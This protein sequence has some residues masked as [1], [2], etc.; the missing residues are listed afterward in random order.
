MTLFLF[1][2]ALL[3]TEEQPAP[4]KPTVQM[5]VTVEREA[6]PADEVPAAVTVLR[7]EEIE[8]LP[9]RS[10]SGA[11]AFAPGIS[12]LFDDGTSGTP[13]ITSR[14][15]FGGGEVEYVKLL[16]DGAPVGDAESGLAD[17]QRFGLGDIERIEIVHG[18][19]SAVH[20]D[21]ALGGVIQLFTRRDEAL[22]DVRLGAGS[23][24]E[25]SLEGGAGG[26][27]GPLHLRARGSWR[28][29]DGFRDHASRDDASG[30]L[31]LDRTLDRSRWHV[32]GSASRVTRQDPGPLTPE[33]L[34]VSRTQSNE[35]FR[36]DREHVNRQRLAFGYDAFGSQTLQANVFAARRAS[37]NLRTI[38]LAPGFG[39]TALRDLVTREAGLSLDVSRPLLGGNVHA[40]GDVTRAA[41]RMRYDDDVA[42]ED[43]SRL[44]AGLFLTGAWN[45]CARCRLVLG[46]RH[47]S[48][49]DDFSS[50]R[51]HSRT[52][53]RAGFTLRVTPAVSLFAQLSRAFKAP[54]IEQLFDPRPFP[55][56]DGGTFTISYSGLRP[57][58][59]RNAELGVSGD[60]RA[61]RWSVAGYRMNVTD[62][63]DFDP[64]TFG[65]R[66]IGSSLHRGAEASVATTGERRLHGSLSYAWTRVA[67]R[68]APDRQLKN[69]PE[70]VLKAIV[71]AE[72]PRDVQA[73][74]TFRSMHGLW[75]DDEGLFA[76]PDAQRVDLRLSR[77]FGRAR[78][79]VDVLNATDERSNELGFVLADFT[80]Q[81]TPLV[82]PSA[83]RS[84][85]VGITWSGGL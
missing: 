11:L 47:D 63:I 56:P 14:G 18:P 80:G 60:T 58:R 27:L 78:V 77:A 50:S 35:L 20:G 34:D 51:R 65:Y 4:S 59:A 73:A 61:L 8:A 1:T 13:M 3:V 26:E 43:G 70:H 30:T 68:A 32:T 71:R 2:L 6:I 57:Q 15:F 45:V 55:S 25:R 22:A 82:Y 19:G 67:D 53:P 37:D 12:M 62:E 33:E 64:R 74:V 31:T 9:A 79:H 48:I 84:V 38:L 83:E 49:E 23:F 16:V 28:E 29:S 24:G 69:I 42:R 21:T 76:E 46:V 75:L 36:F 7:R 10:L 40:G 81:P 85:R 39:A 72:L 52:S 44:T 5:V 17:W 41:L 54:T 66:N